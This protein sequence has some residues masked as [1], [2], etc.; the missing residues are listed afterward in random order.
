MKA[1]KRTPSPRKTRQIEKFLR[2]CDSGAHAEADDYFDGL[3][4]NMQRLPRVATR[5]AKSLKERGMPERA[6]K[7]LADAF[8]T[9]KDS[10]LL[11]TH[12]ISH[13]LQTGNPAKAAEL[14]GEMTGTLLP[15]HA[16]HL[17]AAYEQ[18][19]DSGQAL[20]LLEKSRGQH[21]SKP[22]TARNYYRTLIK[23]DPLKAVSELDRLRDEKNDWLYPELLAEACA[24]TGDHAKTEEVY[25][26]IFRGG[27]RDFQLLQEFIGT[28]IYQGNIDGAAKALDWLVESR[29]DSLSIAH[30]CEIA[31]SYA[32]IGNEERAQSYLAKI[33]AGLPALDDAGL[34]ALPVTTMTRLIKWYKLGIPEQTVEKIISLY[35]QEIAGLKT[36][37]CFDL[38]TFSHEAGCKDATRLIMTALLERSMAGGDLINALLQA[39]MIG[40]PEIIRRVSQKLKMSPDN[41]PAGEENEKGFIS[42][43]AL[44]ISGF[45]ASSDE[46][47]LIFVGLMPMGGKAIWNILN[48]LMK[49]NISPVFVFDFHG[50]LYMSGTGPRA[51]GF[52]NSVKELKSFLNG[53]GLTKI[54]TMGF[55]AGGLSA[56]FYGD[57]LEAATCFVISPPTYI[58]G[59]DDAIDTRGRIVRR[60]MEKMGLLKDTDI[61]A[62]FSGAHPHPKVHIYYPSHSKADRHHAERIGHLGNVTLLPQQETAHAFFG[63]WGVERWQQAIDKLVESA[64]PVTP[65]A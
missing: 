4:E 59:P 18:A 43:A 55:S 36:A 3:P 35:I 13:L 44:G 46:V 33:L 6:E 28:Q 34:R 14:F 7:V 60:R 15:R 51:A 37:D 23:V 29:K 8:K 1:E 42:N 38:V 5:M 57:A 61:L 50:C 41:Q 20:Q 47:A 62:R 31:A 10:G 54:H 40:D 58:P 56:M 16:V 48:I 17:A 30:M 2:L 12:Y 32:Y 24:V 27:S 26:Q 45:R 21:V 49:R 9:H 11:Q 19:G 53:Q 39:T 65:A 63:L 25:K 64:D 52:E 22:A